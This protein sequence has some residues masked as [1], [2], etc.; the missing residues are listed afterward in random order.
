MAPLL[1]STFNDWN[2]QDALISVRMDGPCH[3]WSEINKSV[4][5]TAVHHAREHGTVS[6]WRVDEHLT[7]AGKLRMRDYEIA[8]IVQQLVGAIEQRVRIRR[9]YCGESGR[10]PRMGSGEHFKEN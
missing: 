10:N 3:C 5:R 4:S 2:Y 6:S 9:V 8:L 7:T 1:T